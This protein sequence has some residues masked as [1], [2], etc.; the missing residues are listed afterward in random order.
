MSDKLIIHDPI[1]YN[2]Y[3]DFQEINSTWNFI[4]SFTIIKYIWGFIYKLYLV[5]FFLPLLVFY[6]YGPKLWGFGGYAGLP[7]PDILAS[8]TG[9]DSD[10]W[11]NKELE[12]KAIEIFM[13]HFDAFLIGIGS[14]I[15]IVFIFCCFLCLFRS[16]FRLL[17]P[18]H[19][20]PSK[21]SPR[22]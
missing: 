12:P 3:S 10:L 15:Y 21:R 17:R 2:H 11:K 4:M 6:K 19:Y 14:F 8:M 20:S 22:R 9:T 13:R 1:L 7:L 5:F 16:C 18:P